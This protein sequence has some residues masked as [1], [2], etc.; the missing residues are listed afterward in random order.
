MEV[1]RWSAGHAARRVI[2]GSLVVGIVLALGSWH[3]V[4]GGIPWRLIP[5]ADLLLPGTPVYLATYTE[6][7]TGC[8][9]DQ[10][11]RLLVPEPATG[12]AMVTPDGS[13]VGLAW[14]PGSVGRRIGSDVWV[15]SASGNIVAVT[16]A[17]WFLSAEPNAQNDP[18][19]NPYHVGCATQGLQWSARPAWALP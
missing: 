6:P 3:F 8:Y 16:S 14:P 9:T 1:T 10:S 7:D 12:V 4:L 2:A 19:L 18:N 11:P 15:Y 13:H 17:W 5:G